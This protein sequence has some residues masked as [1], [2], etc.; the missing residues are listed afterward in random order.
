MKTPLLF[1]TARVS[2]LVSWLIA[3]TVASGTT[4]PDVSVTV[5]VIEAVVDNWADAVTAA[6]KAKLAAQRVF[7]QYLPAQTLSREN[8]R[9]FL[10]IASCPSTPACRRRANRV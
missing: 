3:C 6:T 4:P 7:K 10:L 8:T 2:T 1:V 5:P 9:S